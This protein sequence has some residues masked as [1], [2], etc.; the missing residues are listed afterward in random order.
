MQVSEEGCRSN[1]PLLTIAIPTFNRSSCLSLCLKRI[2]EEITY[3]SEEKRCLINVYVSDNASS[4]DTSNI[5]SRYQGLL[6]GI[7]K[8]VCNSENLGPDRNI[9]QC[10]DSAA[11]PYVWIVGDDDVILPGGLEQVLGV[12]L[13]GGIDILYVTK[14][15]FKDG[16]SEK[17]TRKNMG[18]VIFFDNS[19]AFSRRLNV[20]MTFISGMIVRRGIGLKHR[21][22]LMASNLV[23]FSWV[24]PLL[25]EGKHFAIIED[26]V[27]AAKESNSGGYGLVSVFGTNLKQITDSFLK[28]T[29]EVARAIQN[30]TIVNFFSGFVLEFRKGSSKFTDSEMKVGLAAAFGTNW[31]YYVFLAPL[32]FLPL[33]LS[34]CYY[35]FTRILRL[36]FSRY[37]V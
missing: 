24:L 1:Q 36:A 7:F 33:W 31:R 21:N 14:Y 8:S 12:L 15:G 20:M 22:N 18:R 19:L 16:Y 3:L 35:Y 32:M 4:D 28:E 29:P 37:L 5:I 17:A 2:Y 30:G 27:V 23:Q 13:K 11:T 26:W 34:K 25:S 10:Y 9:A 6:A